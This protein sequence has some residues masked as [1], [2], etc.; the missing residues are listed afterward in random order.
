MK[1]TPAGR[2][3]RHRGS[4]ATSTSTDLTAPI[5]TR[6]HPV[7]PR[8][9]TLASRSIRRQAHAY[10]ATSWM[11]AEGRAMS[12][13]KAAIGFEVPLLDRARQRAG[14]HQLHALPDRLR[15]RTARRPTRG[16]AC[17]RRRPPPYPSAATLASDLAMV[18]CINAQGES[19]SSD[20]RR[21]GRPPPPH[22]TPHGTHT[23]SPRTCSST[24]ARPTTTRSAHPNLNA[25]RTTIYY[26]NELAALGPA[27]G[28]FT[29]SGGVY[30]RTSRTALSR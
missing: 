25:D 30:T 15:R 20:G 14:V 19:P 12:V 3:G 11:Q 26:S 1:A 17:Q 5:W 6:W 10:T 24:T 21:S 22:S 8:V 9:A 27:T 23:P 13:I 7:R 29:L 16:C 28:A 4:S 18:Q 2:P